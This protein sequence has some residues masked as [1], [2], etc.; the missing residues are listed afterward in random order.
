[1][2]SEGYARRNRVFPRNI[3]EKKVFVD[4]CKYNISVVKEIKMMT[5]RDVVVNITPENVIL[6]NIDIYYV[7]NENRSE[8]RNI[9]ESLFE[10]MMNNAISKGS[11]D[12]HIEPFEN[13][14]RIRFRVEGDLIEVDKF[15]IEEYNQLDSII[16]LKAGCDITEKRLPQDG[17][18]SFRY[19]DDEVDVRFSSLPTEYGEKVELRLLDKS[20]FL[21][22]RKE[23]GFSDKAIDLMN[24]SIDKGVGMLIVTGPTGSGKS[25]TLY[26]IINEI[27]D[28]NINITTVEDPVEFKIDG[29][30]QIRVN[31]KVGLKFDT[32]LRAIL[33]QDPDFIVVG[34]IRDIETARMA[35]RAALTGHF[36]LT[37]LHTNDVFSTITRLRDIGVEDYMINSALS[38]VISQRL[39]KKKSVVEGYEGEDR[40]LIYEMMYVDDDM[41]KNMRLTMDEDELRGMI[42]PEYFIKYEES[43]NSL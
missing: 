21:R 40:Q 11:S 17:R 5:N 20:R 43:V 32:G 41:K 23:L 4:M 22:S 33:R 8:E 15:P 1:M 28:R 14:F 16:K 42:S 39:V 2:I 36:V 12:I 7:G 18:F 29:I 37:T 3:T 10:E 26:S 27:K 13:F 6:E 31:S 34:E 24:R 35:M 30:N 9:Y 19:G 25:S 38:C